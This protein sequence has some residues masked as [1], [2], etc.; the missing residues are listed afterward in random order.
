M[1]FTIINGTN[2]I[3]NKS[4]E[5]SK[6]SQG[7]IKDL[8]HASRLITLDNFD[9][10]FRGEYINLEN[11]NGAQKVDLENMLWADILIF[12][13]PTYHHGI[14]SALKNF[15]DIVND[16]SV[17]DGKKVGSIAVGKDSKGV[18]QTQ[19]VLSGIF[20]YNENK[21]YILPKV[22]IISPSDIDTKRLQDYFK[23]CVNF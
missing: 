1:K 23:Y 10:L 20:S 18:I 12:V 9:T 3:D 6:V 4:I 11:A 15:L 21:S 19:Q 7:I 17:F 14:P 16:A 13:V 8:G 2:R 5:V 22:A